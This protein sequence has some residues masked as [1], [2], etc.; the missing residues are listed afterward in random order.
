MTKLSGGTAN[1]TFLNANGCPATGTEGIGTLCYIPT[2]ADRPGNWVVDWIGDLTALQF[3]LTHTYV[4]GTPSGVNGHYVLTPTGADDANYL[5]QVSVPIGIQSWNPANP[6]TRLRFYHV[7]D[8][9][10]A[11]GLGGDGSVDTQVFNKK[12]KQKLA[13]LK[14]SHLR[15]LNWG[16]ANIDMLSKWAYR[17]PVNYIVQAGSHYVPSLIAT[18]VSNVGNAYTC[19]LP[20]GSLTDKTDYSCLCGIRRRRAEQ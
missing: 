11:L 13:E 4:S 3:G 15:F 16:Q 8:S 12:F 10:V 20:G 17:K 2:Q 9:P 1:P 18:G 5:R 6:I 19:T 14:I 7:E